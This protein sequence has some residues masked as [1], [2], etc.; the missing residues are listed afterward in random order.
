MHVLPIPPDLR[1]LPTPCLLLDEARMGRNIDRLRGRLRT[2]GVGFSPH[3]KTA[4]CLEVARRLM[5]GPHG[6]ATVATLGEAEAAAAGGITRLTYAVG[7]A[8]DKLERVTVLRRRG[9]DIAV[10]LDS[11]EQ[12]RAVAAAGDP[13][14]PVPALVEIDCD[15]HRSGVRPGDAD[16][17]AAIAR[18]LTPGGRLGGVLTHAG[19]SYEAR[20]R[21]ALEAAAENER[22]SVV[23]AADVLRQAGQAC[24]VVSVGSTPTA[25]FAKSFEGVTEVRAGAFVFF[26]LVQAGI[27]VCGLED[28]ALSV[29]ATVIG[30]NREKGRVIV[31]AGW[32]ALSS[33]RGTATQAVDRGFGLVCDASGRLLPGLTVTALNQEHGLVTGPGAG[34]WGGPDF[35]IG[36]R[37]RILPSHA[38]ATAAQHDRYHVIDAAG[39]VV[40]EW[41]RFGGW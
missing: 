3:L 5:T 26:D 19:E 4:R 32:T 9:T 24:P 20:G 36:T 35:P 28:I 21:A 40:A 27:G 29:L 31:D 22:R 17:L 39:A 16:L 12:A 33:D 11:V 37:L 15:G 6:P 30:R 2:A 7:I 38:C 13:A 1:A 8:P 14:D 25:H 23:L 41:P 34:P 10:L 18:A